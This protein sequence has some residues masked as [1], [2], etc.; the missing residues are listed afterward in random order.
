MIH[1]LSRK[2]F[3]N[4]RT[5]KLQFLL[6]GGVLSLSAMLLTVS[7]LVMGSADDPWDRTFEATHGPH[8]WVVSHDPDLDFGPLLENPVVSETSQVIPAL[9]DNPLVVGDEKISAFLYA[10]DQR[11]EVA[12]PLLAEGRWLDP[13]H[14]YEAVLAA[15]GGGEYWHT[16]C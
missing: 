15:S 3:A 12:R 8:L 9:A 11:P 4:I 1:A 2:L 5:N 6:I 7:L 16:G 13:D 10:M 14:P